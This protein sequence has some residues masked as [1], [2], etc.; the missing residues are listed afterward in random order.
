M[1]SLEGRKNIPTP[2]F[3]ILISLT[4]SLDKNSSKSSKGSWVKTPA[5]SPVFL[6]PPTAP[7]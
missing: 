5:P 6:S 2:K 7:L 1:F 3:P 4:S